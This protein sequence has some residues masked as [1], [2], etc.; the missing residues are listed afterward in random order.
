MELPKL[1]TGKRYTQPL[2][3]AGADALYISELALREKAASRITAIFCASALDSQRLADEIAFFQPGLRI[4]QF[5]DWET[6]PYDTFSPHQDLI[7]ERLATL[8]KIVQRETDVVLIPATTALYR[9][10]PPSFLAAYTFEF[11]QGQKLNEAEL[12]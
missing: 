5:P 12:K 3:S 11:K 7:S 9:V 8:W 2:M 4:T 6:L 10:A 1:V